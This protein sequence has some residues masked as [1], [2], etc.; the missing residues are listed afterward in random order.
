MVALKSHQTQHIPLVFHPLDHV[1]HLNLK[2]QAIRPSKTYSSHP[3]LLLI[4]VDKMKLSFLVDQAETNTNRNHTNNQQQ[5]PVGPTLPPLFSSSTGLQH[6]RLIHP[7]IDN[8]SMSPDVAERLRQAHFFNSPTRLSPI[9]YRRT[10]VPSIYAVPHL[11]PWQ[12]YPYPPRNMD[13]RAYLPGP[14]HVAI[15]DP[16]QFYRPRRVTQGPP[17]SSGS[18][19]ATIQHQI[20]GPVRLRGGNRRRSTAFAPIASVSTSQLRRAGTAD[21]PIDVNT[22][23]RSPAVPSPSPSLNLILPTPPS[24]STQ[25]ICVKPIVAGG[26]LTASPSV[27]HSQNMVSS[28]RVKERTTLPSGLPS[29]ESPEVE[30]DDSKMRNPIQSRGLFYCPYDNCPKVYERRSRAIDH[31]KG[32]HEHAFD[33]KICG[34]SAASKGYAKSHIKKQ[35]ED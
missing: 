18:Q 5:G 21:N 22:L 15:N 11:Q 31:I 2:R 3:Y 12:Q 7:N 8:R 28:Q 17:Q 24:V 4:M 27:S 1:Q 9:V 25:P 6:G 14:P 26:S 33:C 10:P 19:N 35:H 30:E 20:Q 23:E 16:W 32:I 13:R 29:S 34:H